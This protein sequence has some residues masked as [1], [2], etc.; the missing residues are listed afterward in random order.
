MLFAALPCQAP[1]LTSRLVSPCPVDSAQPSSLASAAKA[2]RPKL[3]GLAKGG[4]G[5]EPSPLGRLPHGVE[6]GCLPHGLERNSA[7]IDRFAHQPPRLVQNACR[8]KPLHSPRH[9]LPAQTRGRFQCVVARAGKPSR[10]VMELKSWA[11][12]PGPAKQS[13]AGGSDTPLRMRKCCKRF[14]CITMRPKNG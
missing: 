10:S 13:R 4:N 12:T 7:S 5:N 14:A 2:G 11:Y 8:D 9:S 3:R 1:F 6:V